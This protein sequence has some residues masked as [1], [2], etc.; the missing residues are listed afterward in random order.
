MPDYQS[1][2]DEDDEVFSIAK[3]IFD[4]IVEETE[5]EDL[6]RIAKQPEKCQPEPDLS[7]PLQRPKE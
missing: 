5:R 7:R 4:E 2:H 6:A 1:E 3:S